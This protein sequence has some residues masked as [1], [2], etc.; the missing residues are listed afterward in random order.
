MLVKYVRFDIKMRL[1]HSI[2]LLGEEEE[3]RENF[4]R[5]LLTIANV[6]ANGKI[7]KLVESSKDERAKRKTHVEIVKMFINREELRKKFSLV[8]SHLSNHMEAM[9]MLFAPHST[10]TRY[11]K[12][13]NISSANFLSIRINTA[14]I[15][16]CIAFFHLPIAA[17]IHFT[18]SSCPFRSA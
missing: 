2:R 10:H 14:V 13:F 18:Q 11:K 4:S 7:D 9:T 5:S 1:F 12:S 17:W 6:G 15:Q 3:K 16:Q 8:L